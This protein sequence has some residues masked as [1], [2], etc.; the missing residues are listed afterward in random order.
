M[1]PE[2]IE[3]WQFSAAEAA[4]I[5]GWSERQFANWTRR[6]APFPHKQR[7][8]GYAIGYGLGDLMQLDAAGGLVARGLTPERAFEALRPYGSP[9]RSMLHDPGIADARGVFGKY[10]GTFSLTQDKEGRWVGADGANEAIAIEIRA[11]PIFDRLFPKIKAA[12]LGDCRGE[13]LADVNAAISEYEQR[14]SAIRE[15]R[16]GSNH[17]SKG[18][19]K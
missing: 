3:S 14:I 19:V 1:R 10:P 12:I 7:G 5:L 9:Y 13:K 18:K 4:D 15:Q 17:Y 16:W 11:W 2:H 8:R 6:Y